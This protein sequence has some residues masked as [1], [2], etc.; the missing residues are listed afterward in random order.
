VGLVL[1]EVLFSVFIKNSAGNGTWRLAGETLRQVSRAIEVLLS[2]RSEEARQIEA[3]NVE[4][5]RHRP[6]TLK[7]DAHRQLTI[8]AAESA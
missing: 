8:F 6:A 5:I 2:E 4:V 3:V 7:L 1:N